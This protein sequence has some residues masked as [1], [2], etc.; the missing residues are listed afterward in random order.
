MTVIKLDPVAA[1]KLYRAFSE[2]LTQYDARRALSKRFNPNHNDRAMRTE[3]EKLGGA[4]TL[5]ARTVELMD[6]PDA[7]EGPPLDSEERRRRDAYRVHL[8]NG[9]PYKV[10]F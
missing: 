3:L 8:P 10:T 1:E 9:K 5:V 4:R 2:Q 6:I 7:K